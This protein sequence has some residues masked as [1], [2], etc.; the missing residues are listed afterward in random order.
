MV[1]H[2]FIIKTVKHFKDKQ[3][4][5]QMQ[6]DIQGPDLLS[7]IYELGSLNKQES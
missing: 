7:L 4:L 5:Y 2:P 1:D 3:F 6:E